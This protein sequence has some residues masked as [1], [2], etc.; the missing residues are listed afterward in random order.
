MADLITY[1]PS[2]VYLPEHGIRQ[3]DLIDL[4]ARLEQARDE[5]AEVDAKLFAE[6]APV[7]AEKQPLDA[8]FYPLP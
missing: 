8:G 2:G 1:D 6:G 4:A 7:P 5:V 3:Q